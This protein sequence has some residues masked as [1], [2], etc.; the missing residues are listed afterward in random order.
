MKK[1]CEAKE[2]E[3]L[4]VQAGYT[5]KSGE[6]RVS[7][8]VQS[9]TFYYD[10]AS[11]LADLFDLKKSGYF[12]SR[13]GNPTCGVLE[14]KIAALEGGVSAL[15]TSSGQSAN[16]TAVLNVCGAGD[17]IV[18]SKTIYGGTTNLFAVTLKKLG[19]DITFV[20]PDATVDE[21]EKAV[22]PNTKVIFGETI[23]NPAITVLNF[24]EYATVAEKYGILFV[25]DNTLAT[26]IHCKPFDYGA[27]VVTHSTTKYMD[28][29][30][31]SVGG[32]VVDGGNFNFK[33]NPRYPSF[34]EPDESY[35]GLVYA[36]IDVKASPYITKARVQLIRDTGMMMSPM[37]AF[38]T[39]LG[40]ETLHLR[41]E[42]TSENALKVAEYL[43]S[44]DKVE[45][46]KYPFLKTDEEYK[47]AK[48]YLKGGAG[49]MLSFGLKGD[50]KVAEKFISNLKLFA[51]VTHVADLRSSVIHP[52]STT[53]RQ[54]SDKALEEAG[55]YQNLIRLSIGIENVND[56]LSDIKQAINNL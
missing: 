23:A 27:N 50:R 29:H 36:D 24:E 56:I 32:V 14:E 5:P 28:G 2:I 34:N 40:T 22:Q 41:M 44:N 38:L 35:H 8:I 16:M 46:V 10:E 37:N 33:D 17:H 25:V 6:P 19:I 48:K 12:Y 1:T 13:L 54:L 43:A 31:T 9:T 49:G 7:P 15:C 30:A 55:V 4:C 52:A 26:P 18:C 51:L 42:R 53:H 21:L 47:T 3:T 45:F 39:N 20:K 11:E